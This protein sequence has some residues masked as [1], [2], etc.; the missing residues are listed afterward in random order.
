[1]RVAEIV[2]DEMGAALKSLTPPVEMIAASTSN[3]LGGPINTPSG[4][5][6]GIHTRLTANMVD[7]LLSV[8]RHVLRECARFP[9]DEELHSPWPTVDPTW[10]EDDY[11]VARGEVRCANFNVSSDELDLGIY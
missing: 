7:S 9:S 2:M 5:N 10:S 11:S 8:M 1:M 4:I 3:E 6:A